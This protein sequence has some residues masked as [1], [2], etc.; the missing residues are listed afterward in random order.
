MKSKLLALALPFT[1]LIVGVPPLLNRKV[2]TLI[3]RR[4][5]M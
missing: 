1:M 3:G 4:V 2:I 5:N